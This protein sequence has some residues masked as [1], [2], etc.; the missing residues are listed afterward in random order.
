MPIVT[1]PPPCV[2]DASPRDLPPNTMGRRRWLRAAGIGAGLVAAGAGALLARDWRLFQSLA[3]DP[4]DVPDH[5][6]RLPAGKP[7]MVIA[8]GRD[9]AANVRAALEKMGGMGRFVGRADKVLIK[10][11]VGWDRTQAQGANTHPAVVAE[12]IRACR[13][14][15]AEDIIVTD[16]SVHEPERCFQ[17]SGIRAAAQAAGA[18]VILPSQAH[19]VDVKI[20]GRFGTWPI[21]QPFVAATKIIN[22]PVAKHHGSAR[23]TAGMKNWIGITDKRRSAFHS[24]LHE[25]I[26]GLAQLMRP[27]LTV[28]DATRVLMRNGP[29]GGNL[30]DLKPMDMIA[31]SIDP[32]AVDMWAAGLLGAT[33]SQ[34]PYLKLAAERRLGRLDFKALG[35]VE[36]STG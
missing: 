14:A 25:T 9:P 21:K 18:R 33:P 4:H 12:L 17:R 13:D 16:C 3:A 19:Y 32:V 34:V 15:G 20:P 2:D 7:P 30:A 24:A 27:T 28:V 31:A 1:E 23:V 5:R 10:P 35:A 6:V 8:H 11:N 36:L 26:A 22:V 29:V